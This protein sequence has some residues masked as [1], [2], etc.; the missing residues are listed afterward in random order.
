[1]DS[2]IWNNNLELNIM[3]CRKFFLTLISYSIGNLSCIVAFSQ[4]F[5]LF[6]LGISKLGN[7]FDPKGDYYI[8]IEPISTSQYLDM[9]TSDVPN[10]IRLSCMFVTSAFLMLLEDI[11]KYTG[12]FLFLVLGSTFWYLKYHFITQPGSFLNLLIGELYVLFINS[13]IGMYFFRKIGRL[14]IRWNVITRICDLEYFLERCHEW[15]INL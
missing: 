13:V 1:M 5:S 7:F 10:F 6:L 11:K 8:N 4:G 14:I 12:V 15:L 9:S 3:S 2:L